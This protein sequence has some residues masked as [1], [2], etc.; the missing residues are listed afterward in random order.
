MVRSVRQPCC[1]LSRVSPP[2]S[3]HNTPASALLSSAPRARRAFCHGNSRRKRPDLRPIWNLGAPAP[4]TIARQA[5]GRHSR[6]SGSCPQHMCAVHRSDGMDAPGILHPPIS[7]CLPFGRSRNSVC[8]AGKKNPQPPHPTRSRTP[9]RGWEEKNI[10]KKV[11]SGLESS[12]LVSAAAAARRGLRRLACAPPGSPH[13]SPLPRLSVPWDASASGPRAPASRG[14]PAQHP[15][16]ER[17]LHAY[18][19]VLNTAHVRP[20]PFGSTRRHWHPLLPQPQPQPARCGVSRSKVRCARGFSFLP[21]FSV[22]EGGWVWRGRAEEAWRV[23][24]C[25]TREHHTH[26]RAYFRGIIMIVYYLLYYSSMLPWIAVNLGKGTD[27]VPS[28]SPWPGYARCLCR[29]TA[30]PDPYEIHGSCFKRDGSFMTECELRRPNVAIIII[31]S[32]LSSSLAGT[33][34][35]D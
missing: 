14:L 24:G 28:C 22:G 23:A 15:Q 13:P 19:S 2:R 20:Y 1:G 5:G 17:E 35:K 18:G 33:M 11:L 31:I 7:L 4:W 26:T 10:E 29:N 27:S 6:C 12:D 32:L 30:W 34:C 8:P 9:Q 21:V 16:K 25:F 3:P